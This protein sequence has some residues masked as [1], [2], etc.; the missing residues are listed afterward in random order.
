MISKARVVLEKQVVETQTDRRY[1]LNRLYK[2]WRPRSAE[3]LEPLSILC[4]LDLLMEIDDRLVEF[5][6]SQC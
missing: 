2:Q 3:A 1:F 6:P 5:L 4:L